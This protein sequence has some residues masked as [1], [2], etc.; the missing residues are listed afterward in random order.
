MCTLQELEASAAIMMASPTIVTPQQRHEAEQVFMKLRKSKSPYIFCKQVLEQSTNDYVMFQAA[1]TIKD[2]VLRE[3]A[4]LG[5][6]DIESLRTFLLT[7]ALQKQGVQRYVK[8]QVL[9]VVAVMFKRGSLDGNQQAW[10]SLFSDL[11]RLIT[12][13]ETSMQILGCSILKALLN[14]F[15]F[16][17][18]SSDIGLSWEFHTR[19]KHT[20]E[21]KYLK[22]AFCLVI[23]VLRCFE[24]VDGK[25]MSREQLVALV[26]FLSLAEQIL[27]WEHTVYN[28]RNRKN[29]QINRVILLRPDKS[30]KNVL[31]DPQVIGLFFSIL[32]RFQEN[33]ELCH[34]GFQCL[35]Q[36]ASLCGP[37]LNNKT[38]QTQ[39][40]AHFLTSFHSLTNSLKMTSPVALGLSSVINRLL[41]VFPATCVSSLPVELLLTTQQMMADLTCGFLEAVTKEEELHTE[42]T[43]YMEAVDQILESWGTLLE[44]TDKY[45]TSFFNQ[46]SFKIL[47]TYVRCHL[48]VPD[49]LRGSFSNDN[50]GLHIDE[51]CDLEGDDRELFADQLCSIGMFARLTIEHS[52]PLLTNLIDDRVQ[53]LKGQLATFQ[54]PNQG[55]SSQSAHGI[56]SLF[57]DLH[58]LLL[59]AGHMIADESTGETPLIP[60][61]ILQFSTAQETQVNLQCTLDHLTNSGEL[62]TPS[63]VHVDQ[64]KVDPVIKIISSV[65]HLA[66]TENKALASNMSHCLSPQVSS[67]VV[68]FLRHFSKSYLLPNEHEYGQLSTTLASIFGEDTVGG[69]WTIGFLLEKVKTNLIYWSSEP[70]LAEDTVL[71]LLSLVDS[72]KRAEVAISFECLWQIGEQHAL[73]HGPISQMPSEAHRYL[74]QALVLA[75]SSGEGHPLRERYW[76]QFLQSLHT[77]FNN[78]CHQPNFIKISQDEHIKAELQNLLESFRGVALASSAWNSNHLFHFLLPVLC[79]SVLLMN[80]YQDCPEVSVLVL[81]M[82]VDVVEAEITFL[83][84]AEAE[85]L[86]KACLS[87]LETYAKCSL[88]KHSYSS[89]VEEEQYS[90]LYL[91]MKLLSHIL[92]KDILDFAEEEGHTSAADVTIYGLNIIMPLIST[93]ILK[94]PSIC[95]EYFKLTTYVCDV[96]PEKTMTLPDGLFQNMMSTLEVGLDNYDAEIAKMSM[97][98]LSALASH[99]FQNK[100]QAQEH[101]VV[102]VVRHFLRVIFN[103]LLIESFD[104]DLLQPA[105]EAFLALICCNQEYYS[106]LVRD[107]L[108][109][110]TDPV[111]TQRLLAA[112]NTLTPNDM[113]VSLD[114]TSKTRFRRSLDSFLTNVKGF[115]FTK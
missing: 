8:E 23:Q 13:N 105:S 107:L 2:A 36:L 76:S 49:G 101:R 19:C 72:K 75:G 69:K 43:S 12:G 42:D 88:G 21:T 111:V 60:N 18:H 54:N 33:E 37:I 10:M 68:W 73:R 71:L 35:I 96:Y 83:D 45:P 25:S 89:L 44:N 110:Q 1:S 58:W 5:K 22:E 56:E 63:T 24:A 98:S 29:T 97:E 9:Q 65:I 112:F 104:M 16:I 78:V 15:S 80:V 47:N 90:D 84:Y 92:S 115:L 57:E 74:V 50:E 99:L 31:F 79:D 70:A 26:R 46:S 34:H 66:S 95:E 77:R 52:I 17:N 4:L 11:T 6:E 32:S 7:F 108:A 87:L 103:M 3:W 93:E 39:Y 20:F 64:T 14:E 51:I 48:A 28:L 59:I 62:G 30:W 106:E 102:E 67:T 61:E 113:R 94:F 27:H 55:L 109:Q 85:K 100:Q 41:T 81:E 53:K 114:K 38:E 40:L 91:L 82:F 86:Y